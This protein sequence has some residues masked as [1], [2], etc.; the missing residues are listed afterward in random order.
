MTDEE[1]NLQREKVRIRLQKM[2]ERKR[3]ETRHNLEKQKSKGEFAHKDRIQDWRDGRFDE[4]IEYDRID[5]VVRQRRKRKERNGKEHLLDNLAAKRGMRELREKGRLKMEC[6]RRKCKKDN[7]ELWD[8]FWCQGG[9]YSKLLERRKPELA[10][11]FKA[12][13]EQFVKDWEEKEKEREKQ[14]EIERTLDE[15]G[16]WKYD[17]GEY[18]W[19]IPDENGHYKS[20]GEVDHEFEEEAKAKEALLTP[21]EREEKKR[22]ALEKKR[23]EKE[24]EERMLEVERE[25]YAEEWRKEK[26]ERR[27]ERNRKAKE[28]RDEE[29]SKPIR[30]PKTGEK[31]KYE[32]VRDEMIQQRH[33][34]MKESGMFTDKELAQI[35][36][37]IM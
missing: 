22:K 5:S 19:S 23:K 14:K 37:K 32:K 2:R 34:A 1:R 11:H 25:Y 20:L 31:G 30:M 36:E 8:Q 35:L 12:K 17:N 15:K 10:A 6:K 7:E 18:Y 9:E 29:L 27:L 24:E 21:E 16:R 26:E 4:E 28:K 33:D 13:D 3:E